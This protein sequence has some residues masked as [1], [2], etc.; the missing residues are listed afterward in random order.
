MINHCD[1]CITLLSDTDISFGLFDIFIYLDYAF[2]VIVSN[3]LKVKEILRIYL[4]EQKI[5]P[6][7]RDELYVY[8]SDLSRYISECTVVPTQN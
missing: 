4:I 8:H 5:Y 2:L 3:T 6:N 1:R 7:H